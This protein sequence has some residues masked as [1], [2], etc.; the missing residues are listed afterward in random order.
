MTL[1]QR[2]ARNEAY[3]LIT[4]AARILGDAGLTGYADNAGAL[5]AAMKIDGDMLRKQEMDWR[6]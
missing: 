3:Q 5:C 6:I 4:I 2:I 1:A